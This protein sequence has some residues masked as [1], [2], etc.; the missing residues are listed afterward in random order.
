MK[1]KGRRVL[2]GCFAF[3]L[4]RKQEPS[5]TVQEP[6]SSNG[7][8]GNGKRVVE[9]GTHESSMKRLDSVLWAIYLFGIWR[10]KASDVDVALDAICLTRR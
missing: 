9:S 8:Q 4:S 3:V 10:C 7:C 2:A 1:R 6:G 5:I